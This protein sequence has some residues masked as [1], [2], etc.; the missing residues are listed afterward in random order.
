MRTNFA[1][2][3]LL[4]NRAKTAISIAGI[5]FAILLIFMQLG[6]LGAVGDTA[7]VVYD[8]L[9]FDLMVR[10]PDYLHFI[11]ARTIPRDVLVEL[12]AFPQVHSAR[13]MSVSISGWLTPETKFLQSQDL[14]AIV[15]I[16][17]DPQ[18]AVFKLDEINAGTGRLISSRSV[19]IDR[20][21]KSDYG[22]Q[23]GSRFGDLDVQRQVKTELNYREVQ[24][25]GHFAL[26][27]GLAANGSVIVNEQ[28]YSELAGV[29]P[30]NRITFGLI[31]LNDNVDLTQF[32]HELQRYY[33]Q[34]YPGGPPV[35][36][37]TRDEVAGKERNRWIWRTPIGMIFMMGVV[38]ALVVGSTIVYMVLSSDIARQ[39]NE[40]ATL[41]AM[42]YTNG[43]LSRNV[44]Q[45]ALLLAIAAYLPACLA[46]Y[47]L[48]Q[49]TY[50]LS[51]IPITMTIQRLVIVFVMA[52]VMCA[53][54]G[55]LAQ[56]K[57]IQAEPAAL[58]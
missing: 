8:K 34:Q 9:D 39:M 53:L 16:G 4:S 37:L 5:G 40:L 30:Q 44:L 12:S 25:A 21:T 31:K 43:Y 24:I 35:E 14:R 13:P 26:G 18:Q 17:V 3:N 19:L 33:A 7:T 2:A 28:A 20:F 41:K 45:Q 1:L 32:Q 50:L 10:S 51:N 38:V 11:E 57:V 27:T 22:P 52:I 46:A 29:D 55:L 58:F 56:R 49:L 54:S 15:M 42:G 23:N 47:T 36:I 48:Y 6:F